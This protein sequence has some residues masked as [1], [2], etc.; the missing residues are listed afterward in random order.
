MASA[1]WH[2]IELEMC[3]KVTGMVEHEMES[4][5]QQ[6]HILVKS[7]ETIA[8]RF[9]LLWS[10]ASRERWRKQENE[11]TSGTSVDSCLASDHTIWTVCDYLNCWVVKQEKSMKIYNDNRSTFSSLVVYCLFIDF[12]SAPVCVARRACEV[13]DEESKKFDC[14][15]NQWVNRAT[16]DVMSLR[17]L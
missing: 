2:F 8:L 7:C 9:F 1:K 5:K 17:V 4:C 10:K 11:A 14:S 12:H 16:Y 3:T 15:R 13:K 6:Q